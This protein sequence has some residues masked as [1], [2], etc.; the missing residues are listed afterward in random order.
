MTQSFLSQIFF[1]EFPL[2]KIICFVLLNSSYFR[3]SA[4]SMGLEVVYMTL[5]V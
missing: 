5:V 4:M 1:K 2:A 3:L